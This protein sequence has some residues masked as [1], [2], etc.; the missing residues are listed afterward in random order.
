MQREIL[1]DVSRI[2][3][4]LGTGILTDRRNRLD[5]AQMER[6]TREVA[7][8]CR[9][10][11]EIILV[12]SAAVGAG[13]GVL[14]MTKRPTRL[15]GLQACAAAGQLKLMAAYD[16]HFEAHNLNVAQVLLTHED[17]KHK[18]RHLNA[19]NTLVALLN[20]GIIPII[21]ENDAV[22]FTELKFGD[23]DQL[24]ALVASLLPA[25]LL[26]MLTSVDGLLEGFGGRE[27]QLI[28]TVEAIDS[29]V[30]RLAR[31]TASLTATGGMTTKI[32]AAEIAMKSGIPVV[33]A[34]GRR[35]GILPCVLAGEEVGSLFIPSPRRLGGRKRW[36]AFFH[37]PK[38]GIHV[39]DGAKAAL[40]DRGKSLLLPGVLRCEGRF[41]PRDIVK[42]CDRDGKE[43]AR[44]ISEFGSQEI[45]NGAVTRGKELIHRDNL[46]VL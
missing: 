42:V 18:E 44:G 1:K 23:N 39:D 30:R 46:V 9:A 16:R 34:S 28:A 7:G 3:V 20:R 24:S 13:M 35:E 6:L 43:F 41:H 2:V 8:L 33:I 22:S 25:D 19:R 11:R 14:G 40:R 38:G 45:Q 15:D 26:V 17:L 12:S 37:H 31:G 27:P 4:K 10:G 5:E 29:T 21:N 32:Q 36:I